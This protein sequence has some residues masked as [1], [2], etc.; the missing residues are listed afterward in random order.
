MTMMATL[1]IFY[2]GTINNGNN[3]N[4]GNDD[5]DGDHDDGDGGGGEDDGRS[6]RSVEKPALDVKSVLEHEK[7]FLDGCPMT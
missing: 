6:D 7:C 1:T 3:D 2:S 4:H 5:K